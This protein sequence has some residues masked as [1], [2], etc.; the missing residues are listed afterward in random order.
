MTKRKTVKQDPA[1][2][3]LDT[4][5][6]ISF[7]ILL[8]VVMFALGKGVELKKQHNIAIQNGFGKYVIDK[9]YKYFTLSYFE[10]Y[11]A[12]QLIEMYLGEAEE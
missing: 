12:D 4:F 1:S 8:S 7:L 9:E 6:T 11:T 5:R 3:W 2:S 10:W